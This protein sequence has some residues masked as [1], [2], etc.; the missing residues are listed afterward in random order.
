MKFLTQCFQ[1]NRIFAVTSKLE[2]KF[3]THV[4]WLVD[5]IHKNLL[6]T[7]MWRI[8]VKPI[9]WEVLHRVIGERNILHSVNRRKTNWIGHIS[10]RN[11]L[12]EHVIEG[13]INGRIEET[14]R[15]GRRR[16]QLLENL[17]EMR[18]YWK[19]K[20]E[21]QDRTMESLLWKSL[22]TRRKTDYRMIELILV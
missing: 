8:S 6:N 19:L 14:G 5:V 18:G 16:K 12:L 9:V 1:M 13:K 11:C 4:K 2:T 7:H 15:R 20:E 22:W 10:R 3:R 17:K 21:A